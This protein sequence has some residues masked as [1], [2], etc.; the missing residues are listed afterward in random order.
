MSAKRKTHST[1]GRAKTRTAREIIST[2]Q[3]QTSAGT[4]VTWTAFRSVEASVGAPPDCY[5]CTLPDNTTDEAL[6]VYNLR[7]IAAQAKRFTINL[8]ALD[9]QVTYVVAHGSGE[10]TEHVV[11]QGEVFPVPARYSGAGTT[12]V[13]LMFAGDCCT[14]EAVPVRTVPP[15]KRP[16]EEEEPGTFMPMDADDEP[17]PPLPD[18]DGSR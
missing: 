7:S 14:I 15:T 18:D 8:R 3:I 10:P 17:P 1:A 5:L 6:S 11:P 4:P 12:T 13:T 9:Q 16:G 2:C